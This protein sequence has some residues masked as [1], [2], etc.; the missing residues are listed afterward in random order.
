PGLRFAPSGLRLPGGHWQRGQMT[1]PI[2]CQNGSSELIVIR[3]EKPVYFLWATIGLVII[4]VS[5]ASADENAPFWFNLALLLLAWSILFLWLA[6]YKITIDQNVLSYS[7]L[8]GGTVSVRRDDIVSAE[9]PLGRFQH[10]MVIKRQSGDPI[11]I[12][13]KPFSKA[14]LRIV[15]RFLSE[16]I[17]SMPDWF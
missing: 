14:D 17:V 7:V 11:V 5:S 16:R 13:T 4:L 1:K 10:A 15:I 12:N 9:V 8:F 6:S 3:T 2:G